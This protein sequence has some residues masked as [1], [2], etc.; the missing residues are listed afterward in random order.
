M[1]RDVEAADA[2]LE[3]LSDLLRLTLDR[4]G[5]QHLPLSFVQTTEIDAVSLLK[6]QRGHP[7]DDA[8][9]FPGSATPIF[10]GDASNRQLD[11]RGSVIAGL[12]PSAWLAIDARR[13][14]LVGERRTEQE[15]VDADA[16]VALE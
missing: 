1:H 2:M 10:L 8:R 6:H 4:V 9:G 15:M 5:T 7:T 16:R 14:E 13:L 12:F 3:K 11:P